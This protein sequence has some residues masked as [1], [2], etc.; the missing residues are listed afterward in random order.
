M[1]KLLM[2]ATMLLVATPAFAER[3]ESR[4]DTG[5][6]G[7]GCVCDSPNTMTI[8]DQYGNVSRVPLQV[9]GYSTS[10]SGS[11][12]QG[13]FDSQAGTSAPSVSPKGGEY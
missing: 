2:I 8:I 1:N 13:G 10:S 7:S 6:S 11:T 3:N 4:S 5:K 9:G 12:Y